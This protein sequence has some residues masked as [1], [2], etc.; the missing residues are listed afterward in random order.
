MITTLEKLGCTN[1]CIYISRTGGHRESY[2][3]TLSEVTGFPAQI[4]PRSINALMTLTQK[5]RL[6][7]ATAEDDLVIFLAVSLSRAALNKKTVALVMGAGR[8]FETGHLKY[9]LKRWAFKALCRFSNIELISILPFYL[10][11]R[12]KEVTS[13]WMYD[14]QFWDLAFLINEGKLPETPITTEMRAIAAGRR[15]LLYLGSLSTIKGFSFLNEILEA[16]PILAQ[17]ML[18]V[19][20]GRVPLEFKEAKA[21]LITRGVWFVD[22][23]LSEGEVVSLKAACDTLWAC[24]DPSYNSSSGI[25]GRA[26]QLDKRVIVR[27]GSYLDQMASRVGYPIEVCDFGDVNEGVS[28]LER[29]SCVTGQSEPAGLANVFFQA[30]VPTLRRK[31]R[32][33]IPKTLQ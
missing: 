11:E 16:K 19:V 21:L 28:V 7:F 33:L 14:P 15:V 5:D 22:K 1:D 3:Q 24:Y 10:D 30:S 9:N 23:F 18:I 17:N 26:L 27:R 31:L 29:V 12:F 13:S 8:C 25:F 4:I 20:A 6:L 32:L 2:L